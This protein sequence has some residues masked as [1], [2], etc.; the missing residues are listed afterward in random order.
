[1]EGLERD[2]QESWAIHGVYPQMAYG[3]DSR[4]LVYWSAGTLHRV[5]IASGKRNAIP[6]HVQAT[7]RL[8][9]P[10]RYPVEV[11]PNDFPV[12][13]Q[14]WTQSVGPND[15]IFQALGRLYRHSL[16]GG[17]PRPVTRESK[18]FEFY[19]ALSRDGK[20]LVYVEWTDDGL[21]S[22]RK[23]STRGG[24]SV[25]L[26]REPGHYVEPALS[27]DGQQLVYRRVPSGWLTSPTWSTQRGLFALNLK[28]GEE[29]KISDSGQA[30]HFGMDSTRVFFLEKGPK[31]VRW[32]K[33]ARM[34]GS[35]GRTHVQSKEATAYRVSPDE[36]LLAF[37]EGFQ[38]YLT[39]FP[40]TGLMRS[41]GPSDKGLP[42]VRLSDDS[43]FNPR[44]TPDGRFVTWHMGAQFFRA[45]VDVLARSAKDKMTKKRETGQKDSQSHKGTRYDLTFRV[46]HAKPA[47]RIAVVGARLVT[48]RGN[49]VIE[50]GILLTEGN[51][52]VAIGPRG[53]I[54]VPK[55]AH[56]IDGTGLTAIPGIVDVHAHGAQAAYG[57]NPQRSWHNYATL[58]FGV[59]TVHDPSNHS[60][61][62]FSAAELVK[63]GRIVGPRIFSTGTILY[64][65]SGSFR[66]RIDGLD[67]ARKHLKRMQAMGASSVKSYNQPR[68]NQRQQVLQAAR[69]LRMAVVPEGGAL[70]QHNMSM[71]ADG[72]TGVEHAIPLAH[73]YDDVLQFWTRSQVGYTPTFNVAYGGLAGENYWYQERPIYRH[74]RLL[75][76]VPS[77]FVDARA[78]R[79]CKAPEHEWNHIDVAKFANRLNL[80]G[81]MVQ[82]GGHGQREGLGAHW[83]IW[84]FVQGGMSPH[85][86]LRAA[87]LGGAEYL[88]YARDLG[89]LDA[90]KLADIALIEGNPLKDIRRSAH[91]RWV[92]ANGRVFKATTMEQI[93]PTPAKPPTFFFHA[94]GIGEDAETRGQGSCHGCQ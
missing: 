31:D 51:R 94:H 35:E 5:D 3:P 66:A 74:K 18:A 87:T 24:K 14:R 42:V 43:G 54:E 73:A 13:L 27:P 11:A 57:I 40:S 1:M 12:R 41:L 26:T 85:R 7:R 88:G 46:P 68:R 75:R 90:G 37:A 10:V 67:D 48:M 64:G 82:V 70:F 9:K 80:G 16:E 81:G 78:R 63:A 72:H 30:P 89:T 45:S 22:V 4:W 61:S 29:T 15:V 39:P 53:D 59:T 60:Q 58:A 92:I 20:S 8:L 50:D 44:F 65:A 28:T 71:I 62:V 21:G 25:V 77:K 49:E 79:P 19:P 56:V 76:F 93:H 83:E 36:S 69:E 23:V 52:I 38:V 32:L 34:D 91:V 84:S 2:L 17:K 86:A 6:F 55:N 47:G 33:S